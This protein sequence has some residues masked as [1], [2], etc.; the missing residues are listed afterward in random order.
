MKR[1]IAFALVLLCGGRL[2]A[3]AGH[4]D[5]GQVVTLAEP[6]FLIRTGPD[7]GPFSGLWLATG[8]HAQL[9]M[10]ALA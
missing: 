8:E 5:H 4:D 1:G 7:F 2:T 10:K 6:L 3:A 9:P